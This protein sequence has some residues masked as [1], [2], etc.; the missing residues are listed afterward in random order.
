VRIH[1]LS[2]RHCRSENPFLGFSLL[3][4]FCLRLTGVLPTEART[5]EIWLS[6]RY[7]YASPRIR[8]NPNTESWRPRWSKCALAAGLIYLA[9][10]HRI[11]VVV[12]LLDT[13]SAAA[14][15]NAKQR[16]MPQAGARA[17]VGKARLS[18][19]LSERMS[20]AAHYIRQSRYASACVDRVRPQ[21]SH[22]L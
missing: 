1:T 15:S 21:L 2:C 8:F 3:V 17:L 14:V 16:K 18:L 9:F 13:D 4:L 10:L 5:N 19:V 7:C 12:I 20:S 11:L 6:F 22:L